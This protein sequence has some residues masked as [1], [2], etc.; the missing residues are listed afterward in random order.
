M[1]EMHASQARDRI[2]EML[3]RVEDGE[4]VL[5]T[6][7]GRTVARLE[8]ESRNVTLHRAEAFRRIEAIRRK[9]PRIAAAEI[10][11]WRNQGRKR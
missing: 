3:A 6:R 10:L 1:V 9:M 4:T 8:P 5:I 11:E 2:E 7:N